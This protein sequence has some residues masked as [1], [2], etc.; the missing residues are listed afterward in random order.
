MRK[1]DR[2]LQERGRRWHYVRRVPVDVAKHYDEAM[3]RRSLDTD[4]LGTA[5]LRRDATEKADDDYWTELRMEGQTTPVAVRRYEAAISRA[6]AMRFDYIPSDKLALPENVEELVRRIE[7]LTENGKPRSNEVS[8]LLGRVGEP[9]VYLE[10]VLKHVMETVEAQKLAAKDQEG[11]DDWRKQRLASID[12]FHEVVGRA[13]IHLIGQDEGLQFYDYLVQ[14]VTGQHPTE[15][16]IGGNYANR[17]IGNIRKPLNQY[18]AHLKIKGYENPLEGF[19]FD[20][21]Q[22]GTKEPFLVEEIQAAFLTAGKHEGMHVE[23]RLLAYLL[24]ETGAR[25]AE[26]LTMRAKDIELDHEIPHLKIFKRSGKT[27]KNHNSERIIPLVGVALAAAKKIKENDGFPHYRVKRKTLS[28][29]ANK[30]F[31]VRGLFG[32]GQSLGSLRHS[33]EDRLKE[34]HVDEEMRK[35]LMGHDIDREIYGKFGSLKLKQEAVKSIQLEFDADLL[36]DI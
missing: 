34:A 27:V 35:Y 8:A 7:K 33:F 10:D 20:N 18:H 31:R 21:D 29:N 3:I 23:V 2:Y 6:K 30:L 9:D 12:L 28:S 13:P 1:E 15:S 4:H 11:R 32:E 17:H 5:R 24:V 36:D 25:M 16:Q 26:L 19:S 14:R 22:E